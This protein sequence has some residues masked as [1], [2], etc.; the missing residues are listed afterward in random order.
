MKARHLLW[1]LLPATA[2]ASEFGA[3]LTAVT[4]YDYRGVTQSANHPALQLDSEYSTEPLHVEIW[5]SN[6]QFG[7][8]PGAY[9]AGHQEIAYSADLTFNTGGWLKYNL[10]LNYA[11]Y[12]GLNPGCNYAEGWATLSHGPLSSSFHYAWDYCE[13][14][15]HLGAYYEEIN[16]N[17]PLPGNHLSAVTHVGVSWGPYWNADNNGAYV[18]YAAGVTGNWGRVTVLAEGINTHGYQAIGHGQPF[19]GKAKLL[20]SIAVAFSSAA[21]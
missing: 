12:P 11:T 18:D 14:H 7:N 6:V 16:G 9:E 20:I 4:D 8:D 13:V 3:G 19:S 17:W 21:N 15:P 10:G 5:T 1:T 2:L